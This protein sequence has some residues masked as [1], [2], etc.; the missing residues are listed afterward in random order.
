VATVGEEAS[1]IRTVR[2]KDMALVA[3]PWGPILH[4][5]MDVSVRD[6]KI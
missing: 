4:R 5:R 6:C 1:R 2:G 3:S